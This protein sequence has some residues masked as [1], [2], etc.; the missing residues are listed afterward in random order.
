MRNVLLFLYIII[1]VF[2]YILNFDLFNSQVNM[3]FGFGVYNTM[4]ILYIIV[5]GLVFLLLFVL[6]GNY[7]EKRN[8]SIVSSLESKIALLEKDLEINDLKQQIEHKV[9]ILDTT[10]NIETENI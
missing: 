5:I 6:I 8:K 9:E 1:I 4:P 7:V 10:E 3:D 2:L